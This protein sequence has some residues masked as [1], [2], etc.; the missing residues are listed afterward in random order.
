MTNLKHS[1]DQ[2]LAIIGKVLKARHDGSKVVD[3]CRAQGIHHSTFYRWMARL[4]NT[5][6]KHLEAL[7]PKS[8]RPKRLARQTPQSVRNEVIALARKGEFK[9]A[10]AITTYLRKKKSFSITC[11]TTI[12]IL[13]DAGLY[14]YI[15]INRRGK[16]IKKRGLSI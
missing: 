8:R 3:A 7:R 4:K 9:S 13:E 12:M 14:G 1:P 16:T 11:A 15:K 10:N 6:D 2:K 5:G